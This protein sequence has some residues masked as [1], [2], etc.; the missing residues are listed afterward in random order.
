MTNEE[1]SAAFAEWQMKSF[2]QSLSVVVSLVVMASGCT[3]LEAIDF[4]I[5]ALA[6]QRKEFYDPERN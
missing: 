3:G 6:G 4:A 5:N 2:F 1:I